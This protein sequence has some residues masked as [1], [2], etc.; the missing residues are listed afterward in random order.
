MTRHRFVGAITGVGS[1]SGVRVVVGRW[2]ES[3]LGPFAD[4]MVET[5]SGAQTLVT[6]RNNHARRI[7]ESRGSLL[8][9]PMMITSLQPNTTYYVVAFEEYST[10][11]RSNYYA[12]RIL[13]FLVQHSL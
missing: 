5:A 6:Q 1:S 3:P 10:A 2:R 4:A 11:N 8:Q 13:V 7:R 12:N 9:T